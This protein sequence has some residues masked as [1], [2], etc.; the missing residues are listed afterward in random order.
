MGFRDSLLG[1]KA[2]GYEADHLSPSSAEVKN[3]WS[4]TCTPPYV[5]VTSYLVNLDIS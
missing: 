1:F 4:Y 3:A 2:A 5:F